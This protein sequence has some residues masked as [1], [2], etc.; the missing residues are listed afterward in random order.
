MANLID[1]H[2][3]ETN[4]NG[5][6]LTGANL[7]NASLA[8][9]SLGNLISGELTGIPTILPAGWIITNGYL[10]GPGSSLT[11]L[12]LEGAWDVPPAIIG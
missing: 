10:I 7:D 12:N 11:G 3:Q 6:H 4:L 9:T 8:N 5:A 1:A 2:L